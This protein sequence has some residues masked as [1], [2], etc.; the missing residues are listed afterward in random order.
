M[1][2]S[3]PVMSEVFNPYSGGELVKN[4][5]LNDWRTHD[6]IDIKAAKGTDVMACADGT[7][8]KIYDEMCIRDSGYGAAATQRPPIISSITMP[9]YR[10][11]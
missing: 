9:L 8:A 10:L 6:G 4:V 11:A 2:Y 7:V 1:A 3:L 5:T